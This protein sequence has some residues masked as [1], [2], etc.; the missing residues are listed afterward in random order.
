MTDLPTPPLPL[1]TKKCPHC[2]QWT[3][4]QQRPTDR[5]E[6]CGQELEPYRAA[7]EQASQER[8]DQAMPKIMLIEINP[9][10]GAMLRFFKR[11]IQG[12][13]LAFAGLVAFLVW[14]VT[15]VVG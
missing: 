8:A 10:D 4:W 9:E 6:H 15:L 13:Q 11:V 12:G 7:S 14:V 5:C 2:G 1:A 3:S